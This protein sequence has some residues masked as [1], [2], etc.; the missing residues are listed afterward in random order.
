MLTNAVENIGVNMLHGNTAKQQMRNV[1][2]QYSV[3]VRAKEQKKM[4]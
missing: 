3:S 2:Q 1:A 4:T